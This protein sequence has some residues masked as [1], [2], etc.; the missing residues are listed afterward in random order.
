MTD[1]P[2]RSTATLLRRIVVGLII[3]SF[4]LAAVLGIIVLLGFPLGDSTG[5]VLLTT[6]IVGLFSVGVLCC[7]S[8]LGRRTQVFGIIGAVVTALTGAFIVWMIWADFFH[9]ED[10]FFRAMWTGVA[11]SAG[12]AL[13]SLL[14][15]LV[16]RRRPVVRVTLW[17]TLILIGLLFVL[18]MFSVWIPEFDWDNLIR[19]YGILAILVALGAIVVPVLSLLLPDTSR[20]ALPHELAERLVAEAAAQGITVEQLVAPVLPPVEPPPG[21]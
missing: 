21:A 18:T 11:A 4:G 3:A 19:V 6:A 15:L 17:I 8:L 13:S 9:F 7:A 10:V 14:L 1:Q 12:F 20:A 2:A 16:D 5:R